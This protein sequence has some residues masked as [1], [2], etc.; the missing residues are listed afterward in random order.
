MPGTRISAPLCCCQSLGG[1]TRHMLCPTRE[2]QPRLHA[3][4]S[5]GS[6]VCRF[7]PTQ[8]PPAMEGSATEATLSDPQP[9]SCRDTGSVDVPVT[10]GHVDDTHPA[11]KDTL[12][13]VRLPTCGR[14]E[15][16]GQARSEDAPACILRDAVTSAL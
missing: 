7:R 8:V 16:P 11:H 6:S 15:G 13:D 9:R 1:A 2:E 4:A 3:V 12:G 10:R 14:R 5:G